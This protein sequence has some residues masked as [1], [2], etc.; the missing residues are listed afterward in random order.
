MQYNLA[1]LFREP[2]G[3][4][5][6]YEVDESFIGPEDGLDRAQGWV[7]VIRTHDGFLVRAELETQVN[8]T[9]SRCLSWFELRSVLKMEEE[10][11]PSIDPTTDGMEELPDEADGVI[12]LDDQHVLDMAE[13]LR[14]Y[15]ITEVPIKPLCCEE[16]LG[17]CPECGINLNKEKCKCNAAPVDP[18]WGSLAELLT[19]KQ[20]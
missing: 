13:V 2:T 1:Q 10:S 11:F 9:C 17:L 14:Q 16:C 15:A 4:T 8:L 18:R 3:S 5:R 7:R 19:E 20:D 6:D 12:I